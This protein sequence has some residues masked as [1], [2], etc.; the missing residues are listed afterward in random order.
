MRFLHFTEGY[1]KTEEQCNR[2]AFIL[3]RDTG[4]QRNNV[5]VLLSFYRGDTGRQREEH[6]NVLT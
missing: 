4:R 6:A 5:K 1:R 3:H 2:A